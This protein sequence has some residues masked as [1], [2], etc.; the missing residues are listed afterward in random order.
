M[1]YVTFYRQFLVDLI[2]IIFCSSYV[3]QFLIRLW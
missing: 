2:I 1:Y 3:S